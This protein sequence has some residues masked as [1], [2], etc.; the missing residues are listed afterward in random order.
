MKRTARVGSSTVV[1]VT[2]ESLAGAGSGSARTTL[3]VAANVPTARG[4]AVTTTVAGPGGR[5]PR[6]QVS[7]RVGVSKP[8]LPWEGEADSS[9]ISGGRTVVRTTAV[10]AEGPAFATVTV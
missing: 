6:A 1:V 10:A 2:A 7:V 5:L 8:Q 9:S 4:R 3:A